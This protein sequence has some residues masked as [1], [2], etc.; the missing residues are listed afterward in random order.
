MSARYARGMAMMKQLDERQITAVV[1]ALEDIA[2]DFA[3][4]II[5]FAFGDVYARPGLGL[6]DRQIATIAALIALGAPPQ[7]EAHLKAG[8]NVGL[9]KEEIV[10]IIMQTALYAG[11]PAGLN[12]FAAAKTVFT[13]M[14]TEGGQA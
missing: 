4:L 13:D 7:L 6:R 8:R 5:E 10:E 14:K 1:N 2:P 3:R 12:A 11:F 9:A